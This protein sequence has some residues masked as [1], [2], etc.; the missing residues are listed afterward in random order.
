[1]GGRFSEFFDK[2][3]NTIVSPTQPT[4]GRFSEF[5]DKP[6]AVIQ[7]VTA[8]P[9]VKPNYRLTQVPSAA[10]MIELHDSIN[11]RVTWQNVKDVVKYASI[12]V[13][14]GDAI[15]NAIYYSMY[16]TD[17]PLYTRGNKPPTGLR[18][19]LEEAGPNP[20]TSLKD[21]MVKGYT[22]KVMRR[23]PDI[24]GAFFMGAPANEIARREASKHLCINIFS[25]AIDITSQMVAE[26]AVAIVVATKVTGPIKGLYK[27]AKIRT[28]GSFVD[29]TTSALKQFLHIDPKIP[30][31]EDDV[32]RFYFKKYW[33][34]VPE[35]L[36]IVSPI[37]H[38][39]ALVKLVQQEVN[40]AIEELNRYNMLYDNAVKNIEEFNKYN[41]LYDNAVKNYATYS[42][43]DE[44]AK[45]FYGIDYPS[46][47]EAKTVIEEVAPKI[48]ETAK[49]FYGI[50]YPSRIE[51]KTVDETA[52]RFYGIDYPS[53]I[54]AKTVIEEVAPDV[55][56]ILSD[57]DSKYIIKHTV[58][59]MVD[60]N[61]AS[62][63]K[64]QKELMEK[65]RF[66]A[67][68]RLDK[69]QWDLKLAER[70]RYF[71][72]N[73][74][75]TRALR[76]EYV[77]AF[78]SSFMG[79]EGPI[80]LQDVL[81]L[82][83]LSRTVS[84]GT[85]DDISKLL[86]EEFAEVFDTVEMIAENISKGR[87]NVW[88]TTKEFSPAVYVLERFGAEN[89]YH[90]MSN[91][92]WGT[93]R[94]IYD[95]EVKW[96]G[97][98][99]D[100]GL[101]PK[102]VYPK[103][104]SNST[105][106]NIFLATD[107]IDIHNPN[108]TR[109]MAQSALDA[110]PHGGK[111]TDDEWRFISKTAEDIKTG[112][113]T[114]GQI[115]AEQNAAAFLRHTF[116]E[117]AELGIRQG[118]LYRR[119]DYFEGGKLFGQEI[120]KGAVPYE[121]SYITHKIGV[122][123]TSAKDLDDAKLAAYL[124]AVEGATSVSDVEKLTAAKVS[125]DTAKFSELEAIANFFE[126]TGAAAEKVDIKELMHR[127][128][129]REG[130][131]ENA[132]TAFRAVLHNETNAF[133]MQPAYEGTMELARMTGNDHL[134]DWVTDWINRGIR[135]IPTK[136][137]AAVEEW[138]GKGIAKHIWNP[139]IGRVF[140]S[141]RVEEGQMATRK[142]L[143]T[144]RRGANLLALGGNVAS[145]LKNSVSILNNIPA[146]GYKATIE[147]LRSIS[148]TGG[149]ELMKKS[150]MVFGKGH[151]VY[152]LDIDALT[153][154]E[155]GASWMFRFG[156][157]WLT[158]STA[159]NGAMYKQ[160]AKNKKSLE[161]LKEFGYTGRGSGHNFWESVN[162]AVKG[163]YFKYEIR[164]ADDIAQ[165]TQSSFAAWDL[166]K[167]LWSPMNKTLFQYSNWPLNY[168]A[169]YLPSLFRWAHDGV[170]PMGNM[171]FMERTAIMRHIVMMET[172]AHLARMNGVDIG[173]LSPTYTLTE[174]ARR[175][176]TG[177]NSRAPYLSSPW[178]GLSM[179]SQ[180]IVSE[181][182]DVLGPMASGQ[183]TS[184][185][186]LLK[187]LRTAFVFNKNPEGPFET[188][189]PGNVAQKVIAVAEGEKSPLE[190]FGIKFVNESRANPTAGK[191]T[192]KKRE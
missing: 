78:S 143:G 150:N 176:V 100:A 70:G 88:L 181:I 86:P 125:E 155:S 36:D 37:R 172:A 87:K 107:G 15:S 144:Y 79:K 9:I 43:I 6:G 23:P 35:N 122:D 74:A 189:I 106:R 54:E 11:T 147:G 169:N 91:A 123:I 55:E 173:Y 25:T 99:K 33:G 145:A 95:K 116:D 7:P 165:R 166:P 31:T 139:G 149:K 118:K 105:L 179:L 162:N 119:E 157:K 110:R 113:I 53:K 111:I 142:I 90:Y 108:I 101:N 96:G 8:T 135:G 77:R 46:R 48:D 121:N 73:T 61:T 45:R 67:E 65:Q 183:G 19:Q 120:P 28:G 66:L 133:M 146:I 27:A 44:T 168:F 97:F 64:N 14:T 20:F 103:D 192:R 174:S 153:K 50:D 188:W 126:K 38:D 5:Y 41:M 42:A 159:F 128:G 137:E 72:D 178:P 98:I 175:M 152:E 134:I 164:Q 160:I 40:G 156:E 63:L 180:A 89:T 167:F 171:N 177:D 68:S 190:L 140:K 22:G 148:T 51:A 75:E 130:L 1:M 184:L 60:D 182:Q 12:L 161:I 151:H 82:K 34:E 58:D 94:Y 18:K 83:K 132:D 131:I 138:V 62:F 92:G 52:K 32:V 71:A 93:R 76:E 129:K 56:K 115:V 127:V 185:T 124:K 104:S 187:P 102:T 13:S 21:A 80:Q 136:K 30:L 29:N 154:I 10:E 57:V 49:R 186:N 2:P 117:L 141:T 81:D 3:E 109:E 191:A 112:K 84:N 16:Q 69:S 114:P 17:F 47:I 163:G 4:G 24:V 170:S 85:T 158:T 39:P 26:G 59:N